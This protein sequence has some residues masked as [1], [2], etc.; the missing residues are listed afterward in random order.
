[1]KKGI[2]LLISLMISVASYSQHFALKN[3]LVY[4]A[5]L[6][7]NLGMEFKLG[8]RVTLDLSANYN[9]FTFNDNKKFKHWLAQPELRFWTCEKFNGTFFGIHAHGG[10]YDVAGIKLPFDLFKNLEHNR[11]K[12]Y[13]YGGGISIGH[14]FV[15]SKHWN[16]EA[17]I[18]GGYARIEYDKYDVL[19]KDAP[20]KEKDHYN[21][22]GVTKATLSL[23]YIF[24]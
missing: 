1:M 10:E 13:F 6:T 4:D 18:G 14:Q 22:F 3:N 7:P 12:G 9:P 23:I 5:M 17:S 2:F 19:P 15:L 11:Y 21:Y 20:K 8:K 24:R 16:F